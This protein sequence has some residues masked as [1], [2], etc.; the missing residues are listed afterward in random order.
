MSFN[1]HRKVHIGRSHRGVTQRPLPPCKP[2]SRLHHHQHPTQLDTLQVQ[3]QGKAR[4]KA[5]LLGKAQYTHYTIH[6]CHNKP[7]YNTLSIS[8]TIV[9]RFI[10]HIIHHHHHHHIIHRPHT[11]LPPP[12]SPLLRSPN[13]VINITITTSCN[14]MLRDRDHA[15]YSMSVDKINN[16]RT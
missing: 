11:I 6:T 13:N 3:G 15:I 10:T 1:P 9:S 2:T 5:L 16:R 8:Y 12:S 14:G 7:Q 4:G